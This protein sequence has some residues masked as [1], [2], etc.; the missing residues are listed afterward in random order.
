VMIKGS[1]GLK[2]TP[3]GGGTPISIVDAGPRRQAMALLCQELIAASRQEYTA[4]MNQ[5]GIGGIIEFFPKMQELHALE[6]VGTGMDTQTRPMLTDMGE[7]A[8]TLIGAELRAQLARIEAI[9][10]RANQMVASGNTAVTL[11]GNSWW[12]SDTRTGLTTED[13]D[14]LRG[15]MVF[16]GQLGTVCQEAKQAAQSFGAD[17]KNWDPYIADA[18]ELYQRA[19]NTLNAE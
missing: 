5:P 3:P 17:G 11:N 12:V 16:L 18:Q 9:Q 15:T 4:A 7:R 19:G 8:R 6:M 13:R 14:A 2:Y 10:S 1:K